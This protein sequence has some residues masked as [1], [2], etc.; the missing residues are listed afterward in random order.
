MGR[1]CANFRLTPE[2]Q[3]LAAEN[4]RL[5]WAVLAH[6]AVEAGAY[7]DV[8][9]VG[10]CR[11]AAHYDPGRGKFSTYSWKCMAAEMHHA[12]AQRRREDEAD[13]GPGP[14]SLP[15]ICT[16][17]FVRDAEVEAFLASLDARRR[18]IVEMRMHGMTYAEIGACI[19]RSGEAVRKALVSA[20][21]E[22]RRRGWED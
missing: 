16:D 1:Q 9:A 2:Q 7:Y 3:E 13:D 17:E 4:E 20:A 12:F 15:G 22:Y 10:L 19:S 6:Y 21:R 8:A 11:A 14:A 18:A 5:I